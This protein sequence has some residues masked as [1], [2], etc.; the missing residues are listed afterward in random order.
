M[1]TVPTERIVPVIRE[2]IVYSQGD[3]I[4]GA[5]D[6]AGLAIILEIL[7]VLA[8][9]DG[10]YRPV[11]V[12]FTVGEETGLRGAKAVDVSH[13][14]AKMGLGL[15]AA[16]DPGAMIV[17]APSQDP[18]QARVHGRA[19]HAGAN[20]E[21]GINAI[22]VAAEGIVH[23][24][25]G[26]I[27]AETT[28]NIG[29]IRGRRATNVVPDLVELYG[30]ARSRDEK[31]LEAQIR[32]MSDALQQSAQAHGAT[33]DI[34]VSRSY[35]RYHFAE[36]APIVRLLSKA[37]RSVG[38]EPLLVP[39]GGGSDSNVL[40]ARG[41][42]IIQMSLGMHAVHTN[43]EHIAIDDLETSARIVLACLISD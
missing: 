38:V 24:P 17:H 7:T 22:L 25:L 34:Q 2:G 15:D 41:I 40:I 16:G 5:D 13:F 32:A 36:D 31:K 28:A 26:R 4:L 1:D 19:A 42:D 10:P 21:A 23:M 9:K 27:D 29:I 37:M 33:V 18:W 39:T 3:T 8:E 11:E 6:K 30:E 20:P 35:K 43:D 12:L 14:K